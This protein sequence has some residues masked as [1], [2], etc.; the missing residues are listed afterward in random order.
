MFDDGSAWATT[1]IL[2]PPQRRVR[3]KDD[4]VE[5]AQQAADRLA[6]K[7]WNGGPLQPSPTLR[8]A[9]SDL[10]AGPQ[11]WCTLIE[12]QLRYLPARRSLLL[13]LRGVDT[14]PLFLT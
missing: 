3:I 7:A 11:H 10:A 12:L 9:I 2:E 6:C 8:A 13:R 4:A 1:A 14:L 5:K